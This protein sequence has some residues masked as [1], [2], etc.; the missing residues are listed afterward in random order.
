MRQP[1]LDSAIILASVLIAGCAYSGYNLNKTDM[2]PDSDIARGVSMVGA[3]TR[4]TKLEP[5]RYEIYARTGPSGI[6]FGA[7]RETAR[8]MWADRA[9]VVCGGDNYVERDV[10]ERDVFQ[11][12]N[13]IDL[14]LGFWVSIKIGVAECLGSEDLYNHGSLLVGWDIDSENSDA[15]RSLISGNTASGESVNGDTFQTHYAPDGTMYGRSTKRMIY[16]EEKDSGTWELTA[17][18]EF[19]ETWKKWRKHERVCFFTS[20]LENGKLQ[21]NALG[22]PYI[23]IM[24]IREGD[25]E[26]VAAEAGHP[27]AVANSP[28]EFDLTGIYT[29]TVLRKNLN[30]Y[31]CFNQKRTFQIKLKQDG[32]SIAGSFMSGITGEIEGTVENNKVAFTWYTANCNEGTEGEWTVESGGSYLRDASLPGLGWSELVWEAHKNN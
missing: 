11:K 22:K 10:A 3:G 31:R 23:D 28:P 1:I 24:E 7:P 30:Y 20:V 2:Y 9:N 26:G 8:E 16:T 4:V 15:F 6:L 32:N 25:P 27:I 17:E 18:G 21:M 13:P 19:C 12:G 29:S 14:G 5:H